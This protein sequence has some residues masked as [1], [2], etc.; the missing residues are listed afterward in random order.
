MIV[1]WC[2]SEIGCVRFVGSGGGLTLMAQQRCCGCVWC[3]SVGPVS[4]C[5]GWERIHHYDLLLEKD[6]LERDRLHPFFEVWRR[7]HSVGTPAPLPIVA[8]SGAHADA[9]DGRGH[10]R[11]LP[12]GE[13]PS[14]SFVVGERSVGARLAASVFEEWGRIHSVDTTASSPIV[15]VSGERADVA[16][17]DGSS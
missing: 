6:Q 8:V 17:E 5:C 2:W 15:A 3:A 13:D 11:M 9:A 12:M 7:I 10:M 4:G 1:I 16:S 14:L